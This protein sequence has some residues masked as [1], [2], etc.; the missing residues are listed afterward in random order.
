MILKR[1]DFTLRGPRQRRR[2]FAAM[3]RFQYDDFFNEEFMPAENESNPNENEVQFMQTASL[4][5]PLQVPR[6]N[7]NLH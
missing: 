2:H 1:S 6:Q 4:L 7:N 3:E 5:A